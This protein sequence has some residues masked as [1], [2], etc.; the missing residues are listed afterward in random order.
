M[1]INIPKTPS[2]FVAPKGTFP[3]ILY[4]I[5][6][7]GTQENKKFGN[8]NRILDFTFELPT[9]QK[10]FDWVTKP[11]VVNRE[12]TLSMSEKANLSWLLYALN[13]GVDLTEN[14]KDTFDAKDRLGKQCT[15]TVDHNEAWYAV[16]TSVS[17][18]VKGMS[19]QVQTNPSV[20]MDLEMSMQEINDIIVTLPEFKQ[21]KIKSSPEF[22]AKSEEYMRRMEEFVW[23]DEGQVPF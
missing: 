13:R 11:L 9:E 19:E 3:A 6:D 17:P 21:N 23:E 1:A 7:L 15:V 10:E 2:K 8:S 12:Y 22:I 16:I 18:T 5:I 14:Q 4:K 20:Y